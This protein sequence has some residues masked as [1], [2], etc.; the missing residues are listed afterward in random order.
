MQ[1]VMVDI[2]TLGLNAG[3]IV[4]SIGAVQFGRYSGQLGDSFSAVIDPVDCEKYGLTADAGTVMWWLS[5]PRE[6]SDAVHT[7]SGLKSACAR[8]KTWWLGRALR[9]PEPLRFWSHGSMDHVVLGA[10]FEAVN[11]LVPWG[12][13]DIRDTRTLYELADFD[14]NDVEFTGTPHV[15]IDDAFYQARC[16]QAAARKLTGVSA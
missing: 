10:A 15:A 1:D 9:S 4:L 5:Q 11:I 8:L 12:Y 3:S 14:P 13:R 16:V 2:E 6:A 7:G